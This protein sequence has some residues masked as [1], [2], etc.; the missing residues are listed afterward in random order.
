[1]EPSNQNL[2]QDV[3]LNLRA[4]DLAL[5]NPSDPYNRLDETFPTLSAVQLESVREYGQEERVIK[6]Q[7][8]YQ[9]A[10]RD[11]D[12]FIV[13]R[14]TLEVM[15][16]LENG[17]EHRLAVVGPSQFSGEL[18]LF[19]NRG[20]LACLRVCEESEVLRVSRQQFRRLMVAE[21]ELGEAI[22]RA[23]ILRRTA[24]I[25][26]EQAGV[27]IVGDSHIGEVLRI[28][29][30]LRRNGIPVKMIFRDLEPDR[31]ATILS[32]CALEGKDLPIVIYGRNQVLSNPTNVELGLALGFTEEIDSA[33]VFDVVILGAG[34]AGLSAAVYAASE[35]LK[36]VVLDA[37]APG[38]QAGSSSK[39]ENYLGFP[40]GIS[41]QALSARAQIQ[42]QKFGARIS[43]P[44]RVVDLDCESKPMG[45]VLDDDSVVQ[46]KAIIVA[47]GAQYRKLEIENLEKFE[48]VGVHY[49]ATPLES[50][51]CANEEVIVVGAGNSA[52][53]GAIYLAQNARRVHLLVRGSSLR[54]TMSEYLVQRIEAAARITVHLQA[55]ITRLQGDRYLQSVTWRSADGLEETQA[56]ANVFLMLGARPNTAWAK[57]CLELDEKGFILSG[58]SP[59]STSQPGVF[60]VGDVRSGSIKR[61]ASAVGEGSVVISSVHA[62]LAAFNGS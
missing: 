12:F 20:S 60:A 50:T 62:Y 43:V 24:F 17:I 3:L 27:A 13:I 42:S 4:D 34:P 29:Q 33:E 58:G 44:H 54:K 56:I 9:R 37:F 19:N 22:T 23:F 51:L 15:E 57:G 5:R 45:I 39:I 52:G 61:V 16:I 2:S 59:F 26:H 28:R 32:S 8:L 11:I 36:T 55:E 53:Q 30:F 18:T 40:A 21:P 7:V 47:T 6:G 10:Q 38:G 35:G 31:A 1:M 41:G 46:A 25:N 49:A 14:G 48:G